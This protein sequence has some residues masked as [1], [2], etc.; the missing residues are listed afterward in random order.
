M[1]MYLGVFMYYQNKN[2]WI[3]WNFAAWAAYIINI[4]RANAQVSLLKATWETLNSVTVLRRLAANPEPTLQA[5]ANS[6]KLAR[7]SYSN[8]SWMKLALPINCLLQLKLH[9]QIFTMMDVAVSWSSIGSGRAVPCT[10]M[11]SPQT[12][13][14]RSRAARV[15]VRPTC[16]RHV[17]RTSD[18]SFARDS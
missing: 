13:T 8:P 17:N 1:N 2:K 5:L 14:C 15:P 4:T 6:S 12:I 18:V 3:D 16:W 10:L 9:R 11:T 7:S